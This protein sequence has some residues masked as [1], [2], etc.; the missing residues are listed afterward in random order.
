MQDYQKNYK[1]AQFVIAKGY[2]SDIAWEII[3]KE[4]SAS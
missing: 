3:K 1:A 4:F 2:E